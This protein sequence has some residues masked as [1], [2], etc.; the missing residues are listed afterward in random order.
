MDDVVLAV[1]NH[2]WKQFELCI[3]RIVCSGLLA[4]YLLKI[5]YFLMDIGD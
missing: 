5:F 1:L 4:T 3:F 2:E